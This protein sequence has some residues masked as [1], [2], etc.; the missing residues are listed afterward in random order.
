MAIVVT[1]QG[2]SKITGRLKGSDAAEPNI[3]AWGTGTTA[4]TAADTGLTTERTVEA[5]V[6]GTSTQVNG[7]VADDTYQVVA[8]MTK[9][10]AGSVAIAE[11]G[12][13]DTARAAGAAVPGGAKWL[14][15][16]EFSTLNLSQN[17][18]I[19]FTMQVRFT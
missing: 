10:D 13:V 3:V 6:A 16:G 9:S 12:L 18:S 1:N 8:T 14:M 17:D 2:R 4:H 5:R 15:M 7:G 11:A 19:Q